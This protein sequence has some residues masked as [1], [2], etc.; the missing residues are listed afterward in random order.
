MLLVFIV[1]YYLVFHL[2]S[3]SKAFILY[4]NLY[5]CSRLRFL[6][7]FLICVHKMYSP[8]KKSLLDIPSV[9]KITAVKPYGKKYKTLK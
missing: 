3:F 6:Q 2:L 4:F 7:M 9:I 1:V 8:L 5:F